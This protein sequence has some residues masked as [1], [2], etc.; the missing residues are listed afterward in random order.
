MRYEPGSTL[1]QGIQQGL[2][3]L[4]RWKP[5]Q[6]TPPEPPRAI[7]GRLARAR[8][9]KNPI[10][11]SNP[12][13]DT[14]AELYKDS[15]FLWTSDD[16]SFVANQAYEVARF[17]CAEDETGFVRNC[18]TG[19][20][21]DDGTGTN[22][23]IALNPGDPLAIASRWAGAWELRLYQGNKLGAPYGGPWLNVK[24]QHYP[25]LP[26][27]IDSRFLWGLTN[28]VVFWLV[29]PGFSLRLYFRTFADPQIPVLSL[30]GRLRGFTQPIHT[31]QAERN[32]Q[33]GW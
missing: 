14:K 24:G 4:L 21:F 18:W 25:E 9:P 15:V 17:E 5:L 28:T 26:T 30:F 10:S 22:Q 16:I 11:W 13:Q 23:P 7:T 3:Q 12:A 29:P 8:P 2:S 33:Y 1:R 19:V 32:V 31:Q 6:W 27:W 20:N